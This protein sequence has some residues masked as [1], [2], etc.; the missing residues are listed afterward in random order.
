MQPD[1]TEI[2]QLTLKAP[3][4]RW[5]QDQSPEDQSRHTSPLAPESG[6]PGPDAEVRCR[7]LV[8]AT[9][10]W[11]DRTPGPARCG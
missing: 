5:G 2:Y 8:K 7:V 6:C 4:T 9:S 3:R 1:N 10:A 11:L